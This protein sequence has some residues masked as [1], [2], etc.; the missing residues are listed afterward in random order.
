MRSF[1]GLAR[2]ARVSGH[3]PRSRGSCDLLDALADIASPPTAGATALALLQAR[4]SPPARGAARCGELWTGGV[5]ARPHG[6]A[7]P[8]GRLRDVE[9]ETRLWPVGTFARA[10]L[11]RLVRRRR[12]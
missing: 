8:N 9:R 7:T 5:A 12:R 6:A 1:V 10:Y 4:T 3:A 2:Q 11:H